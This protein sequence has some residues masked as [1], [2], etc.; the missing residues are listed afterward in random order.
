MA[1]VTLVGNLRQFT[2]GVAELEIDAG[3]VRVPH[4]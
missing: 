2:G 1:H 3:T 4:S